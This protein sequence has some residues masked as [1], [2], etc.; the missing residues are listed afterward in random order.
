MTDLSVTEAVRAELTRLGQK[1]NV[2]VHAHNGVVTLTGQVADHMSKQVIGQEVLR[3]PQVL[4]VR[5]QLEVPLPAGDMRTQLLQLLDDE[6]AH[7][8]DLNI[9]AES[10]VI[11]LSGEADGWFDR[12][13]AA[14][15]C[16]MLPAVQKVVNNIR[17]PPG[18][19]DP[20]LAEQSP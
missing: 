20:E 2:S 18:A 5:N 14:R 10:G 3:L 4:D 7:I 11:T 6:N 12:D 17:I 16:W 15:L 19:A 9:S 1:D 13:A 8:R